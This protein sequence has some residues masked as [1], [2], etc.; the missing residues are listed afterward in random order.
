MFSQ[1]DSTIKVDA[2][3]TKS[4]AK[5]TAMKSAKLLSDIAVSENQNLLLS[6]NN[7]FFCVGYGTYVSRK[8]TG[9]KIAT[10]CILGNDVYFTNKSNLYKIGT[11]NNERRI[12]RLSFTPKKIWSG[13]HVIYASVQKGN[14]DRLYAIFPEKNKPIDFI[15]TSSPIISVDE[16]GPIVFILTKRSLIMAF[17]EKATYTEVPIN[18]ESL[19][20]LI[21]LAIDKDNGTVYISSSNGVFLMNDGLFQKVC[22]D[23]GI[24]CYDKDGMLIFNNKTP[25][26]IRLRNNYLY[27]SPNGVVIE[28]K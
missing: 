27:P 22:N 12:M 18:T 15:S 21:S 16:Y 4:I 23:I 8:V 7:C 10:F 1:A 28:I 26:V 20:D 24:L 17:V 11:D 14:G 19:G 13:N 6:S 25:F 3:L 9:K 5:R 2:F